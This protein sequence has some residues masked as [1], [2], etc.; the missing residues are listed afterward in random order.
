MSGA[1]EAWTRLAIGILVFG[2]PVVLVWFL[3]D[4]VRL[5]EELGRPREESREES[6]EEHRNAGDG[7][8][9]V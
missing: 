5:F 1:F 4:A 3:K 9:A 8:E 7:E 2:A 6:R